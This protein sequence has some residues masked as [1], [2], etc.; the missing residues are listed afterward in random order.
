MSPTDVKAYRALEVMKLCNS[1]DSIMT[2]ELLGLIRSATAS[3]TATN[4]VNLRALRDMP[5]ISTVACAAPSLTQEKPMGA[6]KVRPPKGGDGH[7]K[8]RLKLGYERCQR[9]PQPG[10]SLRK[11]PTTTRSRR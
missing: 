11:M 10:R 9:A 6:P 3:R 4:M 5:R 1:S 8:K 2:E 7:P